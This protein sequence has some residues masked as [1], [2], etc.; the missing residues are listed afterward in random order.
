MN[1]Q[2]KTLIKQAREDMDETVISSASFR[3][4]TILEE[5]F[6]QGIEVGETIGYAKAIME[7]ADNSKL[8]ETKKP[9]KG[10]K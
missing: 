3:I 5:V 1:K 9:K 6:Q 4:Q 10:S 7:H 8:E 2:E